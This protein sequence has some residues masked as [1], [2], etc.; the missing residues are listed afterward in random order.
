M[1]SLL[2]FLIPAGVAA[3]AYA[4]PVQV[5]YRD[6]A[7]KLISLAMDDDTG[8]DRLEYLCDRIG[9]RVSGSRS[10]EKAID[11]AESEMTKRRVSRTCEGF[12]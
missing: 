3:A 5:K 6:T 9:N 1:K 12:R 11:W 2:R 7:Q 10:L 4:Q 8:L